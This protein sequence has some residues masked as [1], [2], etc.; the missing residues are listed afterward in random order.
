MSM[1]GIGIVEVTLAAILNGKTTALRAYPVG[2][3]PSRSDAFGKTDYGTGNAS[4][5]RE[6]ILR[7]LLERF[8]IDW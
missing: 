7:V 5:G 3:L 4:G 8:A 6:V 1:Q 2:R